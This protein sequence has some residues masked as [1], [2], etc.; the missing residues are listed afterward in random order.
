MFQ[1]GDLRRCMQMSCQTTTKQTP[2]MTCNNKAILTVS[3]DFLPQALSAADLAEQ[4]QNI[5]RHQL[6]Q[7]QLQ[8]RKTLVYCCAKIH[9]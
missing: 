2:S 4:N 8:Q 1:R 7:L 9:V 3:N 5:I 6:Q